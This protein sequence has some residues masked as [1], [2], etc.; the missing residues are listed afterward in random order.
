MGGDEQYLRHAFKHFDKNNSGYIEFEELREVLGLDN[1]DSKTTEQVVR[2]I[3][4]DA[5]LD[6]VKTLPNCTISN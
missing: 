5:D 6:K 3:L 2:D 4:F 1:P